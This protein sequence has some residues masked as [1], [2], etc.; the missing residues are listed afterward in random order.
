MV[1]SS[2][3]SDTETCRALAIRSSVLSVGEY[4]G[5]LQIRL[6]VLNETSDILASLPML[7]FLSFSSCFNFILI[8]YQI[9][10]DSTP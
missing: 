1:F 4:V 3:K 8:M 9:I 6:I 2:Y 7:M 5:S 10:A